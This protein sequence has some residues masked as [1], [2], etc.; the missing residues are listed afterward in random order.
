VTLSAL[1][2]SRRERMIGVALLLR[3]VKRAGETALVSGR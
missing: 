3:V 2:V 1:N